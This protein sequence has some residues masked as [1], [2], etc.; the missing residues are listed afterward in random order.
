MGA[1]ANASAQTPEVRTE[2]VT[3]SGNPPRS[4]QRGTI[5]GYQSLD[6]RVTLA[7][8]QRLRVGMRTTNRSS[9][10]NLK[11]AN[12]EEAIHNG[13][14]AGNAFDE[15]VANAGDYVIQV[16]LMRNAARRNETARYTLTIESPNAAKPKPDF[17]DGLA[18]GPDFWQVNGLGKGGRLGV[19]SEPRSGASRI[20]RLEN[21]TVA[22]NLG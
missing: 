18:G 10:F 6:Y 14:V 3:L 20:A 11:P 8:G 4:I 13:S 1:L 7:A 5:R 21:G 15:P 16:Y 12:S 19:R 22:R 17:A 2:T 9:Y